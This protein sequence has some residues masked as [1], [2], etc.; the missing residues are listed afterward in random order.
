[1]SGR[2]LFFGVIVA[3]VLATQFTLTALSWALQ[4]FQTSADGSLWLEEPNSWVHLGF[5]AVLAIVFWILAI[6]A[7]GRVARNLPAA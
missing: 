1:V 3:A 2:N 6:R 7:W 4:M 5:S